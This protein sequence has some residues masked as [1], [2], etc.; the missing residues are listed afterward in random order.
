MSEW[1]WMWLSAFALTQLVETPIYAAGLASRADPRRGLAVCVG[2]GFLASSLTHP[3]VW[4]VIPEL[5]PLEHYALF[6]VVAEGFAVAVEALLMRA[7]GL[8]HPLLWALIAN[9]A[10]VLVGLVLRQLIGWP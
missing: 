7:L 2:Y 3:A 10:S 9:G 5:I 4:W 8:R 1:F 6:F